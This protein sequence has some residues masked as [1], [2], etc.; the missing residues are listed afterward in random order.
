M[1]FIDLIAQ[2]ETQSHST[3]ELK[4]VEAGKTPVEAIE[5]DSSPFHGCHFFGSHA[6]DA[7]CAYTLSIQSIF[8]LNPADVPP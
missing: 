4:F 8:V 5:Q 3:G 7:P 2:R 6:K 1:P